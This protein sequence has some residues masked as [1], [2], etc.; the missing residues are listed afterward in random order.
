MDPAELLAPPSA[1][2]APAPFA[3]LQTLKVA[4]FFLHMGP[5]HLWYA[6]LTLAA[7]LSLGSRSPHGQRVAARLGK[8]IP[9]AIALGINLGLV[10]LLFTQVTYHRAAYPAGIL[11]AGPWLAVIP[12][13]LGS[14]A[15]AGG[16]T[17]TW[18]F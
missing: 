4:G 17:S 7:A 3:I 16:F 13:L 14:Y 8:A 12:L 2:G 11:M 15:A 9:I 6:G 18:R 10:P 1:Q 5:M